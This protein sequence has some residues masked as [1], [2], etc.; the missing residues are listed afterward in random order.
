MSTLSFPDGPL[1]YVIKS[2]REEK[3]DLTYVG[4]TVNMKRRIRQHNREIKGGAWKTLKWHPWKIVLVVHGF[5]SQV[6][7]MQFEWAVQNSW[8]SRFLPH[9]YPLKGRK[10]T[11]AARRATIEQLMAH[12]HWAHIRIVNPPFTTNVPDK[13]TT[14]P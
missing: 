2:L 3:K 9:E 1:V 14:N 12:E 5:E 10:R 11:T 13:N 4:F 6:S 8:K 7:A